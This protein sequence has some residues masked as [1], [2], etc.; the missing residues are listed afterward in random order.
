MMGK[1]TSPQGNLV[2]SLLEKHKED[3]LEGRESKM[4]LARKIYT[5]HPELFK[6]VEQVRSYIRAYTGA[7]DTDSIPV[8]TFKST[9]QHGM[10]AL[11]KTHAIPIDDFIINDKKMLT[12]M[13]VHIPYHVVEALELMFDFAHDKEIDS[14]LINGDLIDF[15]GVSRW[16]KTPDKPKV[17]EEIEMAKEF[18]AVLRDLYPT[19]PIYYKLGNHEDRWDAYL[20]QKAPEI[21][22]IEAF[23]LYELLGLAQF[24]IQLIKS[25]QLIKFGKLNIVHGHEFGES[26]F[27]PVNPA[28]GLFL[29]AK[30]STLCGHHH[31]SSAHHENTVNGE[32]MACFTVG[33]LCDLKPEYRPFAFTKWNHG[34]AILERTS[35]SGSFQVNNYRIIDNSIVTA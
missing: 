17:K 32:S 7:K 12:F 23:S 4:G 34:F 11:P 29:R 22:G 10:K 16:N 26:I 19:I 8:F 18:F 5:K 3:I 27:S 21:F 15:Y 30:C 33:C 1:P 20:A 14:I 31:Q 25:K 13:D 24:D 28:R 9:I 6:N 2:K 35:E